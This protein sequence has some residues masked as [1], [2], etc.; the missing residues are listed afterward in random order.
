M[1]P[2]ACAVPMSIA[3]LD[4]RWLS[5]RRRS[6]QPQLARHFAQRRYHAASGGISGGFG[7]IPWPQIMAN[8]CG[9]PGAPGPAGTFTPG[10]LHNGCPPCRAPARPT[11]TRSSMSWT[12]EAA[13]LGSS[14]R[15]ASTSRASYRTNV[16]WGTMDAR[17]T[18]TVNLEHRDAR[19]KRA[20]PVVDIQDYRHLEIQAERQ[21]R[22]DLGRTSRAGHLAA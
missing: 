18:G 4:G 6:D 10:A 22:H 15:R 2:T 7:T 21:S 3:E 1:R 9:P 8:Y 19:R 14:S 20:P 16:S 11:P 13:T 17:V 5:R 12:T